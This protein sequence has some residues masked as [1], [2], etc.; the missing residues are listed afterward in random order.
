MFLI[1]QNKN[2]KVVIKCKVYSKKILFRV[3]LIGT[4]TI[5]FSASINGM[6]KGANTVFYELNVNDNIDLFHGFKNLLQDIEKTSHP[7]KK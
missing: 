3:T 2:N 1:F 4:S 5:I 6:R 7:I